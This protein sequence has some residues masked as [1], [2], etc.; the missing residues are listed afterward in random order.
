MTALIE[1]SKILLLASL[2]VFMAQHRAYPF[3]Y[4][5]LYMNWA[6]LRQWVTYI[7]GYFQSVRGNVSQ[8]VSNLRP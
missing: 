2:M 6:N 3:T 8:T 4:K 1:S 7:V 5:G